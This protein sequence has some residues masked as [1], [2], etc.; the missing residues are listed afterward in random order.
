MLHEMHLRKKRTL[1][2]DEPRGRLSGGD[3]P[4]RPAP[5]FSDPIPGPKPPTPGEHPLSRPNNKM[6]ISTASKEQNNRV[7]IGLTSFFDA[8]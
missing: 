2:L 6:L 8:V 4:P 5:P 3:E 7:Q 1:M